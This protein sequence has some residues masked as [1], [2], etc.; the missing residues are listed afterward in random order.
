MKYY[1]PEYDRIVDE[2]VPK[3]QYEWFA[4][5]SW[6][7]KTYEEFLKDNFLNED[8][9]EIT[10]GNKF[11]ENQFQEVKAAMKSLGYPETKYI[12][13]ETVDQVRCKVIY[14]GH[15]IIGIY[16]FSRHTFVD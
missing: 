3:K 8:M 16:D 6:F 10:G 13:L 15:L 7:H 4:A 5:Q 11:T 12:E 14:S 9:S 1:D 2:S